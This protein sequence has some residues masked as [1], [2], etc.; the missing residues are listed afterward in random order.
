MAYYT[1]A[2]D[3]LG[4]ANYRVFFMKAG[5]PISP[6]H[7]IPLW[8]DQSKR[9][10]NF[11]CEIPQG[12]QP[13]LEIATDEPLNPIKQ[14]T[15]KG[16]L[17]NV[18][19]PY[20]FNYGAF[21]QTWEDPTH[22]DDATNEFGDNDPIDVC[23]LSGIPRKTGEVVPVKILGTYAM[24]D[25][26]ETDWKIL[27]IALDSPLAEQWNAHT[28][29]P[30][31]KKDEVFAFLRDYKIPDGKPANVFAFNDELQNAEFAVSKVTETAAQWKKLITGASDKKQLNIENTTLD[32]NESP[33]VIAADTA[34]KIVV[35]A[36]T[37]Y[38][39]AK[40]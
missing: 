7:D 29:I 13:K 38:V 35:D 15:K 20:P 18:A 6:F 22:K 5:Q 36:F 28:D 24:I 1:K 17:R 39:N 9:V 23:E 3:A 8:V 19:L 33:G 30:K 34:E 10:A 32:S 21:P 4:S 12:T 31:E 2:V 25:E 26:G 40:V 11:V 27:A 14:D 16:K 37:S